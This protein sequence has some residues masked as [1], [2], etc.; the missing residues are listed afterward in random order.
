MGPS[1]GTALLSAPC[2]H[3]VHSSIF[4]GQSLTIFLLKILMSLP[5][6]RNSFFAIL[7]WSRTSQCDG[8]LFPHGQR[9]DERPPPV[10]SSSER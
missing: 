4:L 6:E 8:S 3:W 7:P 1:R 5:S 9:E 10:L 2:R